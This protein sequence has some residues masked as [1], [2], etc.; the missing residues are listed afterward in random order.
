MTERKEKVILKKKKVG[1]YLIKF[2]EIDTYQK[3][4]SG[5]FKSNYL[6]KYNTEVTKS[7]K[8]IESSDK[9][10][11]KGEGEKTYKDL[12]EKY[13]LLAI[14]EGGYKFTPTDFKRELKSPD[15]HEFILV[16]KYTGEKKEEKGIS[17][18]EG[19]VRAF[20]LGDNKNKKVVGHYRVE[21]NK[22]IYEENKENKDILCLRLKNGTILGNASKL[23]YCGA[24]RKGMEAPAQR[25]MFSMNI[26][27]VPFNVFEEAKLDIQKCK[28]VEKGKE[29]DFIMPK[30]EWDNFNSILKPV[31]IY[32]NDRTKK[33]PQDTKNK[34]VIKSEFEER[35]I[36][37]SRNN[38]YSEGYYNTYLDKTKLAKRHFVGAMLLKVDKKYFL[39]DVDRNELKHYRFNP[40]LSELP[41]PC[42]TIK[43]AYEMLKPDEVVKALKQG[44]KVLRQGEWFFIPTKKKISEKKK[45][46]P[47]SIE[48][49]LK[50][51]P[52][53]K[54]Y[55][56]ENLEYSNR[57]VIDLKE[58]KNEINSVKKEFRPML[59]K[60]IKV[61]NK[62]MKIYLE[63]KKKEDEFN[64]RF[65]FFSWGGNLQ[66]GQNRP[67]RVRKLYIEDGVNYVSGKVEHTGREHEPIEL[68]GWYIA[69]PNTATKSFTITGNID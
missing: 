30:L 7:N 51:E 25:V 45:P 54:D 22:L 2:V 59:I 13:K 66:A 69:V 43:E 12:I 38:K 16:N 35:C 58:N 41:N 63:W 52:K 15:S 49:G 11:I 48:N 55:N 44:K 17:T 31:D 34:K 18:F 67:N 32:F 1:S 46:L 4:D 61:Y 64:K 40:F 37:N 62:Q 65:N 23:R 10:G 36:Y 47:K 14:S 19:L 57:G 39:F 53:F 21:D 26:P 42:K 56:L 29:E 8:I 9:K 24:Y 5:F 33:K 6:T 60:R 50:T 28:V 3:Y 20:V 27:L 68:K